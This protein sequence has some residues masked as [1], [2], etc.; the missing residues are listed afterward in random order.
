LLDGGGAKVQDFVGGV[1]SN[2]TI[3]GSP[4]LG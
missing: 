3:I 1:H 4:G 2:L